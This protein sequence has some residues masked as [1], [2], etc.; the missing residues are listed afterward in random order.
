MSSWNKYMENVLK[1]WSSTAKTYSIMHSIS[2]QYYST[3]NKRLGIPVILL[4]AIAS[5]SIFTTSSTNDVGNMWSYIN[6]ALVLLAT[7]L[8][9]ISNFLGV[10]EKQA[11]HTSASFKY[12]N[13]SMNI[14]T[15]LSFPRV[16]REEDPRQFIKEIKMSILEVREHSPDLPTWVVFSYINKLDKSL[17][18]TKTRVNRNTGSRLIRHENTYVNSKKLN[19]CNVLYKSASESP[20]EKTDIKEPDADIQEDEDVENLHL[21][22]TIPTHLEL[23]KKGRKSVDV[24][25]EHNNESSRTN[26]TK[27][28]DYENICSD[29]LDPMSEQIGKISTQF[30]CYT[31]SE[32]SEE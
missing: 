15:V 18:N 10:T 1:K 19:D 20:V 25:I 27:S 12:T 17:I 7:G 23:H 16:N 11:K 22:H 8:T 24:V 29:F 6:G 26:I 32:S 2:A 3:W 21:K 30:Y 31:E 9:G 28:D 13:I 14:D 5:S 4:G